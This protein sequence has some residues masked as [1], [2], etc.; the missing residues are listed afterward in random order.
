MK[1]VLGLDIGIASVGWAVLDQD[2]KRI[3]DLG[4][5]AFNAAE[6]PKT[7]APLAE[8][9]RLARTARRR[10]C[11]RAERLRETKALFVEFRLVAADNG[12]SAY[13]TNRDKTDPWRLRAEALDRLLTGEELARA[14]FHVVKHRGFKSN[15]K[16]VNDPK[17]DGKMLTGIGSNRNIMA[18]RGYRTAGEMLDKNE[19]FADRKRNSHGSYDKTLDRLLLEDEIKCIFQRQRELGSALPS[20][21][22]ETHVL[23]IF[24]RQKPFASGDDILRKVGLCTFEWERGELRAPKFSYHAERAMVLGKVNNLSRALSLTAEGRRK[25]VDMAYLHP[26]VYYSQVR[27]ELSIPPDTLFPGLTSRRRSTSGTDA[28][29]PAATEKKTA[30]VELKG[31]HALRKALAGNGLWESISQDADLMDTLVFALTFYKTD[32]D[33]RAFLAE[34]GV[35]APIIEAALTCESF[36]RASHLSTLALKKIIPHLEEGMVYSEACATAGYDH[37]NFASGDKLDKLPMIPDDIKNPVVRRALCQARKVVNAVIGRYG[38]PY[39]IHI[40]L[41]RDMGRS[42]EDRQKMKKGQEENRAEREGLEEQF[43]EA[44]NREPNGYDLLKWRFYREQGGRCAYSLQPIDTA[45][46]FEPGYAEIDH[47][48]P[49]SR[50][51]DDSRANRV[52]V[53]GQQNQLKRNRTPYEFF[54]GDSA[55]WAEF[56]G[57]VKATFRNNRKRNNLLRKE[58]DHRAQEEWKER[59]LND[60]RWATREFAGHVRTY[61]KFSDEQQ[62]NP[63]YCVNGQITA[64][65]RGLWGLPK[66]RDQDDLHHALDA[67][68]VAAMLPHMI[69]EM[70]RQAR[71][72]RHGDHC[73]DIETGEVLPADADIYR[74]RQPWPRFRREIIARL[75]E[76]PAQAIAQLSLESYVD[77]P[78][79]PPVLVSRMPLR[80]MSGAIHAETIRSAKRVDSD[81]VSVARKFLTSLKETDLKDLFAPETNQRLYAAIHERMALFGND[82]NKAF[83]EP[84]HKP[85]NDGSLGPVVKSVKVCK[86]QNTGIPVRGGVADNAEMVRADVFRKP[87]NME[88]WEY[89][90]VPVYV[91][92]VMARIT[93]RR[94]IA[95]GKPYD[96]WPVMDESFE[97]MFSLHQFDFVQVT[98]GKDVIRGYYRGVD[99]STGAIGLSI[100]NNN[101]APLQRTGVR[102]ALTVEKYEMGVLGEYYPVRKEK[103]CVLE[104][105]GGLEPS[106]TE[107]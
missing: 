38:A 21:E 49:Y 106:E 94:A 69:E 92:D 15:R 62:G 45:R 17:D 93:P 43:R 36:S 107:D 81:G 74:L 79:I 71:I 16:G 86:A 46:L 27:K 40:E 57:W 96:E 88:K 10:L 47:A 77:K 72:M 7:K 65:A 42:W 11:R 91:A 4:V 60:T 85:T 48:T 97:F 32:P 82:A 33:I 22:L 44:F 105:G 76:D 18:E 67:A 25:L 102:T 83:A 51:F 28:D 56:E 52:L 100:A 1:Y 24:N 8:P 73:V 30:F 34:R 37:S 41:A 103:R 50:C 6:E 20:S 19:K 64:K 68:V 13:E 61:L 29:D 54:G 3:E 35:D 99:R 84:L 75:S 70:T 78:D 104:N 89:Y 39:R 55:R 101:A 9:R 26:K 31:Y 90:L 53:L 58:L 59:N 80:K 5:R 87:N 23:E 2:R 63:V 98:T 14:L 12:E 66:E 95:A